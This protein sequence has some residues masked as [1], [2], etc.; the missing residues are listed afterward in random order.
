MLL[1]VLGVGLAGASAVASAEARQGDAALVAG[2]KNR[3]SDC[4]ATATTLAPWSDELWAGRA[5]V[6][7]ARG[8]EPFALREA[9]TSYRKAIA[10]NGNDPVLRHQLARLYLSNQP[11]FGAPGATAAVH[12]LSAALAQNP[13]Y[14]EIQN[15]YG[16]AL[17]ATGD[18]AGA[19]AQFRAASDSRRDF[20]DPLL[21]LATL[22]L[23]DGN[24]AEASRLIASALERNP[25]S[26]RAAAMQA[27]L[28][29]QNETS[30]R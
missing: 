10:V 12:E 2:A 19:A 9:E 3:A 26:A 23:Q 20:V 27:R 11:E 4:Y 14:P 8:R 16:V 15:D 22:E 17:L 13:Y 1:S 7:L 6:A 21:N 30:V 18:R 28:P 5:L 24:T 29:G 25:G